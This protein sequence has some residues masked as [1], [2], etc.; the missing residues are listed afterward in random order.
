MHF[1]TYLLLISKSQVNATLAC[2]RLRSFHSIRSR[3]IQRVLSFLFS[4]PSSS[5]SPHHPSRNADDWHCAPCLVSLVREDVGL[6]YGSD[7]R[8]LLD[9][10]EKGMGHGQWGAGASLSIALPGLAVVVWAAVC[11]QFA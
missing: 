1:I 9:V 8:S 3:G 11:L 10:E 7:G 6:W 2:T 4:H 5:S